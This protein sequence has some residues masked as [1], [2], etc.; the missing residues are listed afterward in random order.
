M[1]TQAPGDSSGRGKGG[2]LAGPA[3]DGSSVGAGGGGGIGRIRINL[4]ATP[5]C[6]TLPTAHLSPAASIVCR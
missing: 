6:V 5:Q 2:A 1:T 3:T 4:V